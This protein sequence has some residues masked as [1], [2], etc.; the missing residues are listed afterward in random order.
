[1]CCL[2]CVVTEF[3]KSVKLLKITP[4]FCFKFQ[5]RSNN[6]ACFI[7]MKA[8]GRNVVPF[9]S[10]GQFNTSCRMLDLKVMRRRPHLFTSLSQLS[11]ASWNLELM[12]RTQ[13]SQEWKCL[14]QFESSKAYYTVGVNREFN[15]IQEA[16]EGVP[17]GNVV[18]VDEGHYSEIIH[19]TKPL[20]LLSVSGA[21]RTIVLGQIMISSS[22]VTIDGFSF[23]SL[24]STLSQMI[25]HNSS[26]ISI[27]NCRFI[28]N[29][30]SDYISQQTAPLIQFKNSFNLLFINNFI[31]DSKLG[32]LI[33]N[34]THSTIQTN[35]FESS[36]V[37]FKVVSSL[38]TQVY[39]NYFDKNVLAL[40][41]ELA[42]VYIVSNVFSRNLAVMETHNRT[43][44]VT[45]GV[46]YGEGF[47]PLYL[48][49]GHKPTTI[50]K[51]MVYGSCGV[52]SQLG[53]R[54]ACGYIQGMLHYID[55]VSVLK[56]LVYMQMSQ[57]AM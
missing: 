17:A 25:V 51:V 41:I 46:N 14:H 2:V 18:L 10:S 50:S 29:Q 12:Y 21:S 33:E 52:S 3:C 20:K 49:S 35:A 44:D 47:S 27:Q 4:L 36:S 19:I 1:M 13:K 43:D 23:Y 40:N 42:S 48:Y 30:K 16:V 15:S 56:C 54:S 9:T 7:S 22:N 55:C 8:L 45:V 37:A 26:S 6:T 57:V 11:F 32:L 38:E 5:I 28:S 53:R 34:G 31:S 24:N 39:A